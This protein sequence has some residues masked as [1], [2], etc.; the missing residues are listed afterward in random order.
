MGNGLCRLI[1]VNVTGSAGVMG[2]NATIEKQQTAMSA[3]IYQRSILLTAH[4]TLISSNH[5]SSIQQLWC[6]FK[7]CIVL[8]LERYNGCFMIYFLLLGL[9]F[10]Q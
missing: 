2:G 10:G 8:Y 5:N 6:I 9:Q 3:Q 7:L 1:H 4:C